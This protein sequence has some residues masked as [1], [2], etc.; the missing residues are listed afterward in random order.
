MRRL[1][2]RIRTTHETNRGV[3][4]HYLLRAAYDCLKSGSAKAIDSQCGRFN[5]A[6]CLQGDVTSEIDGVRGSEEDVAEYRAVYVGRLDSRTLDRN[7]RDVGREVG[8]R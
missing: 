1:R 7:F 3:A 2:H 5:P 8:Y 4:E 6:S